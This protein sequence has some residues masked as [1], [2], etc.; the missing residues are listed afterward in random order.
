MPHSIVYSS[1][2]HMIESKIYG[3]LTLSEVKELISE[4]AVMI[5][6]KGCRLFLS[7]YREAAI[8]LSTLEIYQVPKI[9]EDIFA[10]SGLSIYS[11]KRALVVAEDLKD[12]L[13]FET[14]TVN[15]LQR[16]KVFKDITEA[17]EWL[18]SK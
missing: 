2:A 4:Y 10:S 17:K 7:D 6:E 11:I 16:A 12:Y 14:V 3:D 18:L 8:K 13:F 15:R 1:E 9:F 5:K